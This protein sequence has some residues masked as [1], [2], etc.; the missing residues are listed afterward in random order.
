MRKPPI[1]WRVLLVAATVGACE[2]PKAWSKADAGQ[3][4]FIRIRT[5]CQAQSA[6][7]TTSMGRVVGRRDDHFQ[8]CMETYGWRL[9]RQ[10]YSAASGLW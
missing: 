7:V 9:V 6:A 10:P 1:I 5:R 2:T 3:E 4:E 8:D